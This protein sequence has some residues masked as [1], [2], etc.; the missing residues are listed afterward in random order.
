MT[1][2]TESP[3]EQIFDHVRWNRGKRDQRGAFAGH[4]IVPLS[5]E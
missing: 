1:V 5:V 3:V 4:E 2:L